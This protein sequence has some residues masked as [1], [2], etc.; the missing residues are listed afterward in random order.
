M[1]YFWPRYLLVFQVFSAAVAFQLQ[2][3]SS[4]RIFSP[5]ISSTLLFPR[6]SFLSA[7]ESYN[8]GIAEDDEGAP[9]LDSEDWRAFRARLVLGDQGGDSPTS[10]SSW[11]YDSGHVIE[12]GSISKTQYY[13]SNILFLM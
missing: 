4:H 3:D 10:S 13:Y 6:N 9:S 11:A 12:P 8:D 2:R 5:G 7:S 1:I